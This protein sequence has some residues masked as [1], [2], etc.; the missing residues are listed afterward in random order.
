MFRD[1]QG[2]ELMALNFK[3]ASRLLL[4]FLVAW[5]G[6]CTYNLDAQTFLIDTFEQDN[7]GQEPTQWDH[8]KGNA[9][10][11][12]PKAVIAEDPTRPG[13]KVYSQTGLR[14]YGNK[15]KK[16]L[17]NFTYEFD[18]MFS[19]NANVNI[20]WR[21][22]EQATQCFYATRRR[23]G[24]ELRI[25]RLNGNSTLLNEKKDKWESVPN[26]WY[27]MQIQVVDKSHTVKVK[28][29]QWIGDRNF[30]RIKPFVNFEDDAY[31]KGRV[32]FW[33]ALGAILYVDNVIVYGEKGQTDKIPFA[34]ESQSKLPIIWGQLKLNR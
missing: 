21:I 5:L 13:N 16:P 15:G 33:G 25:Y 27:V 22:Q 17:K 18:W 26:T 7:V 9:F 20:A 31:L 24:T 10:D 29:R 32:G 8:I 3:L 6:F 23:G 30:D 34:I 11:K 1:P 4:H 19:K 2:K 12:N 14:V 28:K